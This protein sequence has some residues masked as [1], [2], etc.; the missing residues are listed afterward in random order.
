MK[1]RWKEDIELNIIENYEELADA[2]DSYNE[3]IKAGTIDEIDIF[4]KYKLN[5]E[6]YV[7][8][9]FEDG[10]VALSVQKSMFEEI[11]GSYSEISKE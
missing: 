2:A 1:I 7:D 10:S 8:I 3:T 4:G 11:S 6:E 5:G 9:Q